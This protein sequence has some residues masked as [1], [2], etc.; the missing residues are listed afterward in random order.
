MEARLAGPCPPPNSEREKKFQEGN[1]CVKMIRIKPL[2]WAC[3]IQCF[4]CLLRQRSTDAKLKYSLSPFFCSLA[5]TYMKDTVKK[6]L[7]KRKQQKSKEEV[8][9]IDSIL[10]C[11]LMDEEEV[12]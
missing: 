9:F 8:L 6:L 3:Q 1:E 5:K 2:S 10:D 7:N 11:D 4:C 12:S